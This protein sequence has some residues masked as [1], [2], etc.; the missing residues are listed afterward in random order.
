MNQAADAHFDDFDKHAET[1]HAGDHAFELIAEVTLH[2]LALEAFV[3]LATGVFGTPLQPGAFAPQV[4][5]LARVIGILALRLTANV[6][7]Q[8]AVQQQVGVAPDR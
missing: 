6:V 8:R 1:G 5:H 4:G 3:D 2:V 7:L